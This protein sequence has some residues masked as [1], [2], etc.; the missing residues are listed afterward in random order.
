[1]STRKKYVT[2]EEKAEFMRWYLEHYGYNVKLKQNN[3]R[4]LSEA[5][6]RD[7][8]IYIPKITIYRWFQ[9]DIDTNLVSEFTSKYIL[10]DY[11]NVTDRTTQTSN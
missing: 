11:I 5:Y 7:T 9:K 1:M 8:G 4:V 10:D 2:K 6:Q 3:S